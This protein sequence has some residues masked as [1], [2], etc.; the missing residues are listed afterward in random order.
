MKSLVLATAF[1]ARAL[2][3]GVFEPVDF[4]I[5]KALLDNGVTVS[6]ISELTQ[7]GRRDALSGCS[8]AVSQL[9]S[10]DLEHMTDRNAVQFTQAHLRG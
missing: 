4:N 3:Q 2:S 9:F 10:S 1:V 5:T 7:V 6:S 8:M